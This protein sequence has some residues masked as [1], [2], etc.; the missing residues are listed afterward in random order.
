MGRGC[1]ARHRRHAGGTEG[2]PQPPLRRPA[3]VRSLATW[4][5]PSRL[6]AGPCC[7]RCRTRQLRNCRRD[8]RRCTDHRLAAG[9]FA[10]A[11]CCQS[12][13]LIAFAGA[14]TSL[15][16]LPAAFE[17]VRV[18]AGLLAASSK[19][20][21]LGSCRLQMQEEMQPATALNMNSLA[22]KLTVVPWIEFPAHES[23]FL[24]GDLCAFAVTTNTLENTRA[25]CVGQRLRWTT[26]PQ[27]PSR[28]IG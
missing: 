17:V 8:H 25:L 1:R 22:V 28:Y 14:K 24:L 7:F 27:K 4:P 6:P 18:R 2:R 23:S 19:P 13:C 26:L 9:I 20:L 21:G 11:P 15:R 5:T 12:S 10:K 16:S 3:T